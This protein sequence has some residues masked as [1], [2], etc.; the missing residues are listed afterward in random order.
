MGENVL[1]AA[2]FDQMPLKL[3]KQPPMRDCQL[4]ASPNRRDF[5]N[6]L[7]FRTRRACKH[8]GYKCLK[9]HVLRILRRQSFGKLKHCLKEPLAQKAGG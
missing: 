7:I 2:R 3:F 6:G 9:R 1:D 8:L 4:A 5:P